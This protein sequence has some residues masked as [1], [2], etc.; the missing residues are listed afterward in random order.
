M[1][2]FLDWYIMFGAFFVLNF[3]QVCCWLA[4][5]CHD[6]TVNLLLFIVPFVELI[7]DHSSNQSI[8]EDVLE[9]GKCLTRP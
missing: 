1:L 5:I 7:G 8:D 4:F 3:K 9:E 6:Y 2:P